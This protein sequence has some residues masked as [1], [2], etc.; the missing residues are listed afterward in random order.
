M[1]DTDITWRP[2]PGHLCGAI[3]KWAAQLIY[4]KGWSPQEMEF[5]FEGRFSQ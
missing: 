2:L 5:T 3:R 1:R 4:K